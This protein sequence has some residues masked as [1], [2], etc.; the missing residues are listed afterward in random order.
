MALK[1]YEREKSAILRYLKLKV[2]ESERYFA[3]LLRVYLPHREREMWPGIFLI[4]ESFAKDGK[5]LMNG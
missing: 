4:F 3:K 5:I 1:W 2:K